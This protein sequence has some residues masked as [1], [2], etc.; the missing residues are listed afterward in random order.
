M[1]WFYWLFPPVMTAAPLLMVWFAERTLPAAPSTPFRRWGRVLLLIIALTIIVGYLTTL[2]V[3]GRQRWITHGLAYLYFPVWGL[4]MA[5]TIRPDPNFGERN[6]ARVERSASLTPRRRESPI[7][8]AWWTTAWLLAIVGGTGLIAAALW[9][10]VGGTTFWSCAL[11]AMFMIFSVALTHWTLPMALEE[12]EPHGAV[13][14]PNLQDEYAAF[15]H[16]RTW[17]MFGLFAV[18]MPILL[19]VMGVGTLWASGAPVRGATLG[20]VGGVLGTLFGLL[21]AALGVGAEMRRRKLR[22]MLHQA[23]AEPHNDGV[24]LPIVKELQP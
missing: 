21:G 17:M 3:F 5:L 20:V 14:D 11:F 16:H 18:G 12:P 2:G 6:L 24:N 22:E 10:T 13:D 19:L 15:R 1:G 8:A 23:D 9:L 4:A 7:T